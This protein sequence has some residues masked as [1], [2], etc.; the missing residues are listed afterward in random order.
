MTRGLAV[1]RRSRELGARFL[2]N[3]EL[4]SEHRIAAGSILG[5]LWYI[6]R[7]GEFRWSIDNSRIESLP[8]G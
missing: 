5:P 1:D 2:L 6:D 7:R 8:V 4:R 3:P